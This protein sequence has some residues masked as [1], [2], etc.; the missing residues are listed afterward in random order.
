MD[1]TMNGLIN[2]PKRTYYPT[3]ASN[4][5]IPVVRH[6]IRLLYAIPIPNTKTQKQK[7]YKEISKALKKGKTIHMY[8]EG[9]LWPYYEKIRPFKK[10]RLKLHQKQIVQ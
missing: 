9:A 4:F 5:K 7:F 3:L 2:F 10:E 1:C 8:P 6:L